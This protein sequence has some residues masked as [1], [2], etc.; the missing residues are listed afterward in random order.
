MPD[1]AYFHPI[2]VHIVIVLGITG[3]V[4]RLVSLTGRMP[5]TRPAGTWLILTAAVSGYFAAESG[6]QAHGPVERVPGAREAV[7]E[8]EEAGELARNLFFALAAIELLALALRKK[9]K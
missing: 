3:V 4:C 6:H 7:E 2:I 1:I 5:W 8:H 9:E